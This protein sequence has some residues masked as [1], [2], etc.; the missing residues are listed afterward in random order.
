MAQV[1]EAATFYTSWNKS[2]VLGSGS[3][4]TVRKCHHRKLGNV[5]IKCFHLSGTERINNLE[6][7][8]G[9]ANVLTRI[10]HTSIVQMHGICEWSSS[11]GIIT[12]L[13]DGGNL[14]DLIEND[15]IECLSWWIRLRVLKEITDGLAYLHYYATGKAFV[16][17]DLKPENV[18]LT[19]ELR[20]KIADFGSA[21]I[22]LAAG[23]TRNSTDLPK[24]NQYTLFYAAPE[25]LKVYDVDRKT[26]MDV[27]RQPPYTGAHLPLDA[28]SSMISTLDLR[29]NMVPVNSLRDEMSRKGE[30]ENLD[31]LE[32][33]QNL[34]TK[35]WEQDSKQRPEIKEVQLQLGEQLEKRDPREIIYEVGQIAKHLP[36]KFANGKLT[37]EVTLDKFSFPF[38]E[39]KF[40][41]FATDVSG[42]LVDDHNSDSSSFLMVGGRDTSTV[43]LEFFPEESRFRTLPSLKLGRCHL[44]LAVVNGVVYALCGKIKEDQI[45]K[46]VECLKLSNIEAGWQPRNKMREERYLASAAVCRGKLFVTGGWDKMKIC[47]S[48]ID[49]YDEVSDAW[50][51]T[52]DMETPREGHTTVSAMGKLYS[53]G[54]YNGVERLQ[55]VECYDPSSCRS[56]ALKPMPESRSHHASAYLN[57]KIYVPGGLNENLDWVGAVYSYDI[58][59]DLWSENILRMKMERTSLG[60]AVVQNRIYA[61]GGKSYSDSTTTIEA[62]DP[63]KD[64]EWKVVCKLDQ[65]WYRHSVTSVPAL[66]QK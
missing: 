54:G 12:D 41:Y 58:L 2:D 66:V 33:L 11:F 60:V 34:M 30:G 64:S 18:L 29:P 46:D 36:S 42:T 10:Q 27:Y 32:I 53:I 4:G 48:S 40:P 47:L 6:R 25:V 21:N 14:K 45:S 52:G 7:L 57:G 17:G 3:F 19:A 35:C 63:E 23:A 22:A 49:V 44:C 5:A 26:P 51:K 62:L 39:T 24:S 1:Y 50:S 38:R 61:V 13:T 65:E 15:E 43:T 56:T 59:L 9:E 31:I 20:V 37:P 16:H 8:L 28:F 55:S